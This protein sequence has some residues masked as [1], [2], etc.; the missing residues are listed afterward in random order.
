MRISV[1]FVTKLDYTLFNAIMM[2]FLNLTS[3]TLFSDRLSPKEI[4][5]L[6]E[7]IRRGN[8]KLTIK[9]FMVKG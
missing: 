6:E 4:N 1:D 2:D 7:A 3:I 5:K 9:D 8:K